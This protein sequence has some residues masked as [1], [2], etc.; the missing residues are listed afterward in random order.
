MEKI[1]QKTSEGEEL[2]RTSFVF[3]KLKGGNR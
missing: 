2:V 3:K 1:K